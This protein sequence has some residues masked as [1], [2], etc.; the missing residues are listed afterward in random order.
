MENCL[1]AFFQLG[2]MFVKKSRD[3]HKLEANSGAV[4]AYFA[5]C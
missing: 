5:L 4:S 2:E 1:P 3:Y